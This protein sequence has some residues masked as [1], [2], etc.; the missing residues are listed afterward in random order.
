M[1]N[2]ALWFTGPDD[3]AVVLAEPGTLD[4]DSL[5]ALGSTVTGAGQSISG[6]TAR[7]TARMTAI[8]L[9]DERERLVRRQRDGVARVD[10]HAHLGHRRTPIGENERGR[11]RF[12]TGWATLSTPLVLWL[13]SVLFRPE[14]YGR[15]Q[16]AIGALVL[17]LR[18]AE[19][20]AIPAW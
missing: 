9:A 19:G 7:I 11:S 14:I 15:A 12:L 8:R 6:I 17:V 2:A 4:L 20:A 5:A 1:K 18:R 3:V 10:P 13:I 16:F